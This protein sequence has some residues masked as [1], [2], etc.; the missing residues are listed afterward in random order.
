VRKDKPNFFKSL[1]KKNKM[2]LKNL[3]RNKKVRGQI[4]QRQRISKST[5]AE[6]STPWSFPKKGRSRSEGKHLNI[7]DYL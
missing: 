1:N 4:K 7:K 5:K 6:V 2:H 3:V